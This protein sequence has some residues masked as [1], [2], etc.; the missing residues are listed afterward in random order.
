[1]GGQM[2]ARIRTERKD[3]EV[4]RLNIMATAPLVY[5]PST[6]PPAEAFVRAYGEAFATSLTDPTAEDRSRRYKPFFGRLLGDYLR[7]LS[8]V[9]AGEPELAR[10]VAEDYLEFIERD[11]V[12]EVESLPIGG[13]TP[14][15]EAMTVGDAEL[16]P[17]SPEERGE[18]VERAMSPDWLEKPSAWPMA[19]RTEMLPALA[20]TA[21]LSVRSRVKK[22]RHE[23]EPQR[24]MARLV[25]ALQLME[26][27]LIGAGDGV[28]WTEPGPRLNELG[29]EVTLP[30]LAM[31]APSAKTFAPIGVDDLRRALALAELIPCGSFENS[32][33]Q[34]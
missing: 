13:M 23:D 1:P 20:M 34:R 14:P 24:R 18:L 22:R 28:S 12:T 6:D 8:T 32:P 2:A 19:I 33:G 9:A 25:L 4:S 31:S 27:D 7:K 29:F 30:R 11:E 21:V 10:K 15:L 3:V 16:R 26:F 5:S 17:L